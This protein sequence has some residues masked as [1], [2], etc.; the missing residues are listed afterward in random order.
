MKSINLAYTRPSYIHLLW[1]AN[2]GSGKIIPNIIQI[3]T[4]N[5]LM[6]ILKNMVASS[7][8]LK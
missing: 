4:F 1:I 3:S 6:N 8:K 2:I 5:L 7:I